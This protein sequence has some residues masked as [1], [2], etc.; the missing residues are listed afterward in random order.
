MPSKR[1]ARRTL[2]AVAFGSR[3]ITASD[4]TLLP[5]PDSPTSPSVEPRATPEVDAVDRDGAAPAVAVEHDAQIFDRQQRRGHYFASAQ[6]LRPSRNDGRTAA[7]DR[8][9]A[10][11]L[12][13]RSRQPHGSRRRRRSSLAPGATLGIV[14]ESGCGKSVT[15]LSIMGLLPKRSAR[16]TGLGPLR[17]PRA[18]RPA[19]AADAGPA[20]QPAGHDLPG[21]D[22]L[23]QSELHVGDQ[24][25]E[26]LL[27]HRGLSERAG[28]RAGDRDAAPRAAS[29][30]PS[31]RVDEYPHKL[32]GGMRQRV[33]IAMA[34]A[35]EPRA[36]DRRRADHRAR[37]HH[38]GADPRPA[39]QAA[40][41]RPAPPIILITHDLGVVAE[42]A[43]EVA[44]MYAGRDRRAG[45]GRRAVR[46]A[47]ASL[48]GRPARLDPASIGAAERLPRSTAGADLP[49]RAGRLPLRRR[50]PFAIERLPR[51]GA[52]AERGR[53][54]RHAAPRCWTAP[55]EKALVRMSAPL[56]S[57]R[58]GRWS[59]ISSCA[60]SLFGRPRRV[61]RAV[62]G[63]ELHR[64]G[65]RDAGAGRRVRLRQVD[66]RPAGAAA[67]RADRGHA[68]AST[69]ED[70]V[71]AR[72][73]ASCARCRAP[74]AAH[75]PGPLRLAQSAHDGRRDAGRA[76]ALHGIVPPARRRERVARAAA[77]RRPRAEHAQR[78]PHE[79]SGGQRQRIGIARALAVE[80]KL[81]VCD[82]PVSALDVSIQA[83][84]L[85][86]LQ[87]LQ[88]RLGL[89]YIFIA[90]T[91]RW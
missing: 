76:A 37:R 25:G 77:H 78:Y 27:R 16:V 54:T 53:R 75:L 60:R 11:R 61:V 86:L 91:W 65:R 62:D 17:G 55:L 6:A 41:R 40:R 87:D 30:R 71:R 35:C 38:P 58:R 82:E 32:S 45:A 8:K 34:L 48:H 85:N 56:S 28:A 5:Q 21:A 23:A 3:P 59:S 31:E 42:I 10:R 50:C 57:M 1:H 7:H 79:F 20:R 19:G 70:L 69:A 13:G 52:A 12:R 43:D 64:R 88:Q 90:T 67:D 81:I 84:I 14:G 63:V 29:P 49:R 22:D 73:R 46:D 89:A 39:A 51:R 26:A 2:R 24:I 44:V 18:A 80:P 72:R 9:S 68:C 66:R 4:V 83:Q 36:A 33:M 47:A 15:A 74:G